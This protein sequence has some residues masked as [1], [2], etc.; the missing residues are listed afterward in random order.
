MGDQEHVER[1]RRFAR[2]RYACTDMRLAAAAARQLARGELNADVA[3][4]LETG[5][6]VCYARPF[7]KSGVG[8]LDQKKWAPQAEQRRRLHDLLIELRDKLH[9]HTDISALRQIVGVEM[10]GAKINLET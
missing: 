1:R 2:F 3:E 4:A 5:L 7:K 6:V 8:L 10:G 9:A